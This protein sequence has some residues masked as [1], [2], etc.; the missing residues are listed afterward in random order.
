MTKVV[1]LGE[2]LYPY[3]FWLEEHW[4]WVQLKVIYFFATGNKWK[5]RYA[6]IYYSIYYFFSKI[7]YKEEAAIFNRFFFLSPF[8]LL[9][10]KTI[11]CSPN[12]PLYLFLWVLS[13]KFNSWW[14]ET[15]LHRLEWWLLVNCIRLRVLLVRCLKY[16]LIWYFFSSF[17]N[18]NHNLV[19]VF[20]PLKLY[21]TE[22][23]SQGK[24]YFCQVMA[25]H[26]GGDESFCHF[27]KITNS[28]SHTRDNRMA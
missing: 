24:R 26:M 11:F 17:K 7:E 27:K 9:M 28:S 8:S 14:N 16:T 19:L 21:S 20:Y 22:G 15:V 18:K 23:A 5:Q 4:I 10:I 13:H 2:T 12:Q 6:I 1:S 3:L 25:I